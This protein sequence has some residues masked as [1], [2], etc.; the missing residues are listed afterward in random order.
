[1]TGVGRGHIE[2][3]HIVKREESGV[4]AEGEADKFVVAI[5]TVKMGVV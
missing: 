5:V 1:M 3:G 2:H 4:L